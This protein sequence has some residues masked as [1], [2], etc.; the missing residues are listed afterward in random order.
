MI[1]DYNT[2]FYKDRCIDARALVVNACAHVLLQLHA[3]MTPAPIYVTIFM[4]ILLV[5]DYYLMSLSL[6][7]KDRSFR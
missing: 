4:E 7:Y 1:I 6:K 3:F 2:F 5:V